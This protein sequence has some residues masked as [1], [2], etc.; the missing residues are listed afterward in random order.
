MRFLKQSII[1]AS[2]ERVFAFHERPDA[3]ALLQPPWGRSEIVQPP[4]SLEVGT[5]VILRTGFGPF[6][7]TIEAEH[8]AYEPGHM[9][10]DRMV[11]GP[12]ASWLHKHVVTPRGPEE[13]LLTDDIEYE[14]PLGPVGRLF[15]GPIARAGLD[16]L[17]AFRHEVTRR[18]CERP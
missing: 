17:F 5:R 12:F 11:R 6:L 16:R 3:F 7:Q 10:A 4:R 9:F 18:E 1:R 15:G 2:A 14:L 13:S 8:V